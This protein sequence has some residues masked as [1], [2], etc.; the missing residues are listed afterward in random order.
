MKKLTGMFAAGVVLLLLAGCGNDS[1]Q[2]AEISSLK[3]DVSSLKKEARSNDST[4]D[5]DNDDSSDNGNTGNSDDSDDST[6]TAKVGQELQ[7]TEE[8]TE[9]AITVKLVSAGNKFNEDGKS[10]LDSL[11]TSSKNA[12]QLVFDYAN[13]KYDGEYSFEQFDTTFY[14][15]TG[16]QIEMDDYDI[17]GGTEVTKSHHATQTVVLKLKKPWK[18]TKYVEVD[19]MPVGV[20]TT[21]KWH[22][23]NPNYVK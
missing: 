7:L 9:N 1:E 6:V 20:G 19:Q 14:D 8:S 13:N 11:D 17:E 2:D 21:V 12:V 5:E 23:E 16:A 3:A 4:D 18:N 22:V 10:S 15:D